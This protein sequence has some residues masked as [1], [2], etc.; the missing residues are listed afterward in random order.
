MNTT[1][2]LLKDCLDA[3]NQVKST[4]LRGEYKN[5]YELAKVVGDHLNEIVDPDEEEQMIEWAKLH[6]EFHSR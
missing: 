4:K 2:L 6:R 3:L 5:T 1:E